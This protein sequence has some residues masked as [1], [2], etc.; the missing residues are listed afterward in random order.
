MELQIPVDALKTEFFQ[1][2]SGNALLVLNL[3]GEIHV[4]RYRHKRHGHFVHVVVQNFIEGTEDNHSGDLTA[5]SDQALHARADREKLSDD[6]RSR[7]F[8]I[9]NTLRKDYTFS[10]QIDKQGLKSNLRTIVESVPTRAQL[11]IVLPSC[12]E[13]TGATNLRN[14]LYRNW[15]IQELSNLENVHLIDIDQCIG[16]KSERHAEFGDHF[17]RIV[18]FRLAEYIMRT[19]TP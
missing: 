2:I 6:S 10:G 19:V 12:F 8:L 17:D 16:D 18:Y 11:A 4:P 5:W 7:L 14:K 1:P 15:C 9:V 13:H 3:W